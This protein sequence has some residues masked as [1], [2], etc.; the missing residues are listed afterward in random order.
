MGSGACVVIIEG[1][2][3][4]A[5]ASALSQTAIAS[6]QLVDYLEHDEDIQFNIA[7]TQPIQDFHLKARK[8]LQ[9]L[10]K[11]LDGI[12]RDFAAKFNRPVG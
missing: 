9:K 2:G 8:A 4:Q 3:V 5:D 12:N 11:E 7:D 6:C 10:N 1:N